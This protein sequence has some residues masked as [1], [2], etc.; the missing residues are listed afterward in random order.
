MDI[1]FKSALQ[2]SLNRINQK[3][4]RA[5]VEHVRALIYI[6]RVV[7]ETADRSFEIIDSV[8][9]DRQTVANLIRE[10]GFVAI[11]GP[12]RTLRLIDVTF[13]MRHEAEDAAGLVA[14][15]GDVAHRAVRV[16]FRNVTQGETIFSFQLIQSR[17]VASHEL[18]FRVSDRQVHFINALQEDALLALDDKA[19]P[20][21]GINPGLV[22]R[23]GDGSALLV[24]GDKDTRLDENLEAVADTKDQLAGVTEVVDRVEKTTANLRRENASSGDIVAVAEPA[25]EAHNLESIDDRRIFQDTINVNPFRRRARNL[26]RVGRFQ[27]TVRPRRSQNQYVRFHFLSCFVKLYVGLA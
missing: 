1:T 6:S 25:G 4:G 15:A 5:R 19:G 13:R 27:I 9:E 11:A 18:A 16:V 17:G 23:Q 20:T 24:V 14:N 8:L 10:I 26:K 22:P 7:T 3:P 12:V 21:V 2:P